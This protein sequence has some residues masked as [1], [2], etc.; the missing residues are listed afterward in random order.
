MYILAPSQDGMDT[1]LMFKIRHLLI[2]LYICCFSFVDGQYEGCN[3]IEDTLY[4]DCS[5]DEFLEEDPEKDA[6]VFNIQR[7]IL[8]ALS[9]NKSFITSIETVKRSKLNFDYEMH[10]FDWRVIPS[11]QL[12]LVGGGTVGT[13]PTVG[14][15][16]TFDKKFINGTKVSVSP[17]VYR[18]NEKTQTSLKAV[19]CQPVFRGSGYEYNT[20]KLQGSAFNFRTS[21]RNLYVARSKLIVRVLQSMYEIIRQDEML[22][23]SQQSYERLKGGLFAAK[24]KEKVGLAESL[25]VYR[26]ET[27]LKNA[28]ESLTNAQERLQDAYDVFRE[29]LS[30]PMCQKIRI[31]VPLIYN[32]LDICESEAVSDAINDRIE[33]EQAQDA[34]S[35]QFRILRWAKQNLLPDVNL[36]FNYSNWGSEEIFTRS[37]GGRRQS[38]WGVGITSSSD[39][40][41]YSERLY[42]ENAIL[43]LD[44]A[45]RNLDQMRVSITLE[46]KRALRTL[47]QAAKKIQIQSEQIQNAEGEYRLSQ[48]KF[49]RGL[50]SNFD[51]I[52][53]E[54][55]LRNAQIAYLSAVIEH[56]NG[57]YNLMAVVGK[58]TEKPCF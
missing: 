23:F 6:I 18:A 33:M 19:V 13:G 10:E 7:A 22:R 42:F 43:S 5:G 30:L 45:E 11:T 24:I 35:E 49:D 21:I 27:E 3:A 54:R 17:F 52:Q 14:G 44:A 32:R 58:L 56:I 41:Q 29:L 46:V 51:V 31:E 53:A 50:A 26:A 16:F 2:F 8:R 40:C 12:G 36:V 34:L 1:K 25:D 4:M 38:T 57:E 47:R 9:A 20:G 37:E 48:I 28:E 39:V 55:N 15:G